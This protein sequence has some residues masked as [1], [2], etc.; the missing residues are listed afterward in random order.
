MKHTTVYPE[1]RWWGLAILVL[2]LTIIAVDNTILNVTL[3]AISIELGASASE[4][5]WIVDAYILVFAALQL[6]LGA[7]ADRYG[8]KRW[9]QIGVILFGMGSI[10]AAFSTSA[11]ML[12]ATRAFMGLGA[13]IIMPSTLSLVTASFPE[14]ER[15]QAIAI[16]AGAF[17]LGV[18]IGPITGGLLLEYFA[19]GSV[20]LVNIPIIIVSLIGGHWLLTESR[21]E[22]APPIDIPGSI[23]SIT[24]LFA[25]VYS[26]IKAGEVG[27]TAEEVVIAFGASVV[28]LTLFGL[29]ESYT[30]HPMLP[31]YFFKNPS[32]TGANLT[33]ALA[34]FSMFGSIFFISQYLQTVLGYSALETG[35]RLLPLAFSIAITSILS[36][37][38]AAR[39][40]TKLTVAAGVAIAGIGMM[41]MSLTF[42]ATSDYST[43]GF[44]LA[45]TA[46]GI[47]LATGPATEAV[48]GAI[49]PNKAGVG[50]AM[51]D[52]T[53]ELGGA[54]GVA[55]LGTLANNTY[56][57]GIQNLPAKLKQVNPMLAERFPDELYGRIE[58]SIQAAHIIAGRLPEMMAQEGNTV[59]DS[60]LVTVQETIITTANEAFVDGMTGAMFFGSL[61]MLGAALFVLAILPTHNRKAEDVTLSTSGEELEG[62]AEIFVP[63]GD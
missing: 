56:I 47:G 13:G 4:L 52:T 9:L 16:W 11:E 29:W 57:D 33:L 51:N 63:S 15:P 18:G 61:V 44:A 10:A 19:W 14:D 36:A 62:S 6:T 28:L 30:K 45:L 59:P 26:I 21:D 8:R 27:W 17:G 38:I 1:N 34:F 39:F 42:T 22:D 49:P 32:F 2:S 41:V 24:G 5:Q 48:M 54:L 20:F 31:L 35:I 7:V 55:I 40:G 46:A 3:P 53:R 23:L 12:I 25:L 58:D 43:V 37:R 60:M 50:S